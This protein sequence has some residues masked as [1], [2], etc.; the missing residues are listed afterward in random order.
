M[1][2]ISELLSTLKSY[3]DESTANFLAGNVSIDSRWDAY[4]KELDAIGLKTVLEVV[5]KVYDRM[6]K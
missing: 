4:V 3:V 5:Q 1:K 6:Y 2:K